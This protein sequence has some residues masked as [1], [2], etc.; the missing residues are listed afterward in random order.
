M[1]L[2][3]HHPPPTVA[4]FPLSAVMFTTKHSISEEEELFPQSVPDHFSISI[5]RS[6]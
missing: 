2:S 4:L 1:I 5:Q 6:L 3:F